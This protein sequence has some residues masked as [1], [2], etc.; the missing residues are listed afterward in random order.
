MASPFAWF[1]KHTALLTAFLGVLLMMAFVVADPLMQYLGSSGGGGGATERR[2][3]VAVSWDGGELTEGELS[4][5]VN[6]RQVLAGFIQG[7][8]QT[9]T[10]AAMQAG[11]PAGVPTR[12]APLRLPTRPEEGV[13]QDVVRTRLL[14]EA[15]RDAGMVITDETITE[16]LMA[17]GRDYVSKEEMRRII[18]GIRLGN[19]SRATIDFMFGLLREAL[20][21]RSYLSSY[22]YALTTQLPQERWTDWLKANNRVIVEAAAIPASEF[23]DEVDTPTETQLREYYEQYKDAVP[24]PVFVQNTE[25]PSPTP[26]FGIPRRA[27]VQYLKAEFE[28]LV[29]Q[30]LE[31][32]TEE[33]VREFYEQNKDLFVEADASWLDDAGSGGEDAGGLG[34]E[35]L[36]LEADAPPS[37]QPEDEGAMPPAEP[38]AADGPSAEEGE[39]APAESD[40]ATA[41]QPPESDEPAADESEPADAEAPADDADQT[42]PPT[43]EDE[44]GEEPG[45]TDSS[46]APTVSPFRLVA[47][48][49]ETAGDDEQPTTDDTSAGDAAATADEPAEEAPADETPAADQP[50]ADESTEDDASSDAMPG[51]EAAPNDATG[52]ELAAPGMAAGEQPATGDAASGEGA[53]DGEAPPLDE[54]RDEVRQQLARVKATEQLNEKFTEIETKLGSVF[55]DYFDAIWTARD[56]EREEP[57]PPET[58]TDLEP[59]ANEYGL[60]YGKT[61]PLSIVQMRDTAIGEAYYS[62]PS[63]SQNI[64]VWVQAFRTN[65]KDVYEAFPARD[66]QLNRYLVMVTERLPAKTP[67]FEEVRQE[68]ARAWKLQRAGELALERA[69]ELADLAAESDETLA[70]QFADDTD[71]EVF[72]TDPFSW[73]QMTFANRMDYPMLRLGD[74]APVEAAGPEFM[75]AVFNLAPGGVAAA[76]NHDRSVAYVVRLAEQLATEAELRQQFL[77]EWDRWYGAPRMQQQHLQTV[78]DELYEHLI[79]EDGLDWKRTPDRTEEELM[80]DAPS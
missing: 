10:M 55:A 14:A 11:L 67:D 62:D 68:V 39:A 43:S 35:G 2:N 77:Q 32:L 40:P 16:Y 23:L 70:Q 21:A 41:D 63:A 56:A 73:L 22:Q 44:A 75:E 5:L 69:E 58:L 34:L 66:G 37:D 61:E 20:L 74:P 80:A 15:A 59:I 50:S 1:R 29:Q 9:G 54:I 65:S 42:E 28:P 38:A 19:N 6:R 31:S 12:V 57:A 27:S 46:A 30:Q 79:G 71:M 7:L 52:G 26:A 33:E 25:L 45:A 49:Q 18:S 8:Y 78:F 36:G 72:R 48:Q 13:E 51:D 3:Q 60:E 53:A 47:M 24:E 76:P 4:M 17:L 64:P